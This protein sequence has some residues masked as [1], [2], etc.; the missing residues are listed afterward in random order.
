MFDL[1]SAISLSKGLGKTFPLLMLNTDLAR[2][3]KSTISLVLDP[4]WA[5]TPL[6]RCSVFAVKLSCALLSCR[7]TLLG[8]ESWNAKRRNYPLQ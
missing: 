1:S 8:D 5:R 7:R 3:K 2:G 6:K 4:E